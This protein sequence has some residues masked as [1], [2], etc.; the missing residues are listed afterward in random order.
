MEPVVVDV[1]VIAVEL[2]AEPG[3]SGRFSSGVE[4]LPDDP[5]GLRVGSFADGSERPAR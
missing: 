3:A 1:D 5:A 4:R 2:C